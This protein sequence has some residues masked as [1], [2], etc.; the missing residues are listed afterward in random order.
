MVTLKKTVR[1]LVRQCIN[2][3]PREN[4]T[5]VSHESLSE[6]GDAIWNHAKRTTRN[7]V[8]IKYSH[9]NSNTRGI[10]PGVA[11]SLRDAKACIV[12]SPVCLDEHIFDEARQ[13]GARVLL[14]QNASRA[15]MERALQTDPVKASNISRK[16]ADLFT[17][18]TCIE[19][20]SPSG[21]R[22]TFSIN[23]ILGTA[24]TGLARSA[25]E[26]SSLPAGKASAV[27]NSGADGRI[28]LDRIAGVRR[29]L[30]KPIALNI[31]NGH[32]TQ[33]KGSGD[34]ELLRKQLRKFGPDG[35]HLG[36]LGVGANPDL[37]L[38]NSE[39]EDQRSLGVVY[40]SFGK[41]HAKRTH[42]KVVEALKGLVLR[43][44]VLIDGHSVVEDGQIVV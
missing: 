28:V 37:I 40:F 6:I 18:G 19:L 33:I 35:R 38:G 16:L 41:S 20:R 22:A 25:G 39:D 17:I 9:V 11:G 5:V 27:L 24:E 43:P 44:T 10:S 8:H 23:K 12:L 13:N 1:T 29:K 31:N 2:L 15:L 26:L 21:T 42:G 4:L 14:L 3:Q 32:I 7:L 36:E 34:A 30:V